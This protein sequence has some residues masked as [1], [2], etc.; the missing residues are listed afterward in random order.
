MGL[1]ICSWAAPQA[2]S[3]RARARPPRRGRSGLRVRCAY[4]ELQLFL[5]AKNPI[6]SK[7][8]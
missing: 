2:R 8:I 3:S 5:R 7:R 4:A 6:S 1:S